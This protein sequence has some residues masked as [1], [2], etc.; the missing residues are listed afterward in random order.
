MTTMPHGVMGDAQSA[1][2][3]ASER[4]LRQRTLKEG[5][6]SYDDGRI[7]TK[8]TVRDLSMGGAK[9]RL[10]NDITWPN[11]FRL[12]VP[13]D[14]ITVDCEVRWRD[15]LTMGVEFVS[16]MQMAGA[17]RPQMKVTVP[18]DRPGLLRRK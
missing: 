5:Q 1:N 4:L 8:C 15:G 18:I 11:K 14:G 9:L 16:E 7:S 3:K 13:T 2:N 6:L 17:Q 10:P 12:H